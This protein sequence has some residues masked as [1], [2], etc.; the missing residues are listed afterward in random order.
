MITIQVIYTLRSSSLSKVYRLREKESQGPNPR[1]G[2]LLGT[3]ERVLVKENEGEQA[4]ERGKVEVMSQ[5][6]R[7]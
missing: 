4:G 3:V 5:K 6:P 7:E 2:Q 1:K